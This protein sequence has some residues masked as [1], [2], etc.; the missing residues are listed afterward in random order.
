MPNLECWGFYGSF[1]LPLHYKQKAQGV[2]RDQE[3][4]GYFKPQQS[5]AATNQVLKKDI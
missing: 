4:D 3:S 5:I 2:L 1:A